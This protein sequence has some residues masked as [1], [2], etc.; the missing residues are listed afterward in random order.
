VAADFVAHLKEQGITN[1]AVLVT[2]HPILTDRF[3]SRIEESWGESIYHEVVPQTATDVRTPITKIMDQD[4]DAVVLLLFPNQGARA[5]RTIEE[6]GGGDIQLVF[7]ALLQS[8]FATYEEA[9]SDT[10][11]LDGS[12]VLALNE[13]V[14][15]EFSAAYEAE[16]GEAPGT[17]STFGYDALTLLVETYNS[18]MEVWNENIENTEMRG[19]G[20]EII[21]DENGVRIPDYTITTVENGEIQLNRSQ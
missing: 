3:F 20:G 1:P 9:L 18:D 6:L 8:G 5:V 12:I 11:I 10:S 7:D 16:Y 13:Y 4:P 14:S 19:V 2:E 21:F 15:D 17:G